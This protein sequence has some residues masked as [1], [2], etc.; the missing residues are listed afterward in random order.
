MPEAAHIHHDCQ[1]KEW[2]D[3][4]GKVR[5]YSLLVLTIR[6]YIDLEGIKCY[7]NLHMIKSGRPRLRSRLRGPRPQ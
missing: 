5:F 1:G 3:I 4:K 6:F 2:Y 7:H